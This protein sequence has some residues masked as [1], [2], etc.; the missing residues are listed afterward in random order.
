MHTMYP[1]F[2]AAAVSVV[3]W[4]IGTGAVSMDSTPATFC[5]LPPPPLVFLLPLSLA[6]T[7]PNERFCTATLSHCL[8][9]LA[10]HAQG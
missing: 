2:T 9:S 4:M 7:S 3:G 6:R 5:Q 10:G 8:H 1:L